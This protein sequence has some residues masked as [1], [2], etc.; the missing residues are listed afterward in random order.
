MNWAAGTVS[1]PLPGLLRARN[2]MREKPHTITVRLRNGSTFILL[3]SKDFKLGR[4]EVARETM[5]AKVHEA[6][7]CRAGKFMPLIY[8]ATLCSGLRARRWL[9]QSPVRPRPCPSTVSQQSQGPFSGGTPELFR[10]ALALNSHCLASAAPT[11]QEHACFRNRSICVSFA[12]VLVHRCAG[13]RKAGTSPGSSQERAELARAR[14]VLARSPAAPP[15]SQH[16]PSWRPSRSPGS[17]ALAYLL[18]GPP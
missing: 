15:G 9:E 11:G 3:H 10:E 7:R 12:A 13:T 2:E 18:P 1:C 6:R 14:V 17:P 5:F 16:S 4:M 8:G